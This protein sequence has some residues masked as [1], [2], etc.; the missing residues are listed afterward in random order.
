VADREAIAS[1]DRAA[2]QIE[3]RKPSGIGFG[4]PSTVAPDPT[5]R[6]RIERDRDLF[7]GA[8]ANDHER[9]GRAT[10]DLG[11]YHDVP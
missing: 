2:A 3:A 6:P 1:R 5:V 8:R 7:A 9:S 11:E 4:T 10:D